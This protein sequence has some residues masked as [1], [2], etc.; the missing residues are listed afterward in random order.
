MR[1]P[2]VVYGRGLDYI[3]C[4][5]CCFPQINLFRFEVGAGVLGSA[6][7]VDSSFVMPHVKPSLT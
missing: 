3:R 2:Y 4:S 5:Y 1:R 6:T 7:D